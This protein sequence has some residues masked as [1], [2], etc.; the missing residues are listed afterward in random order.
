MPKL[1]GKFVSTLCMVCVAVAATSAVHAQD[2]KETHDILLPKGGIYFGAWVLPEGPHPGPREELG[3]AETEAL[4]AQIGRKLAVHVHYYGWSTA[5]PN[6]VMKQ[7]VAAGRIP[8]VSWEGGGT[9]ANTLAGGDDAMIIE[10]AKAAKA[11]GK[12]MFIRYMWEMNLMLPGHLK[13]YGD[14]REKAAELYVGVWKHVWQIFHDQGV[15]NVVWLW[16]PSAAAK[17]AEGPRMDATPFYPG[18]EF[19]DWIGMDAYERKEEG[20]V[21]VFSTFYKAFEKHQKPTMIVETGAFPGRQTQFL[22]DVQTLTKTQFPLIKGFL[23]FDA[24]GHTVHPW[25]LDADAIK[26]FTELGKDPYFQGHP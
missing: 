10:R 19:V 18:D 14:S 12:P 9:A 17:I 2:K 16:N 7:D 25:S 22:H 5:F 8:I 15:T 21:A 23:Y 26:A 1:P 13:V 3:T 11:F 6:E 24:P 20:Y 4:E